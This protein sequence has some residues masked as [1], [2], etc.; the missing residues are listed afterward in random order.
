MFSKGRTRSK[1]TEPTHKPSPRVVPQTSDVSTR[2]VSPASIVQRAALAPASLNPVEVLRL[3]RTLGNRAVG[4]LLSGRGQRMTIQPKLAVNV[5]GDKYEQ[6]AD[7]I[8]GQLSKT[9]GPPEHQTATPLAQHQQGGEFDA[10]LE[11]AVREAKGGGRHLAAGIRQRA[12]Q[13]LGADFS[14]VN[15][16]TDARADA[17]N[18]SLQARA[19][20][21]GRDIFFRQGEYRPETRG[22]QEL[23]AHELTHVAQQSGGARRS[24]VGPESTSASSSA[25]SGNVFVQRKVWGP[26]DQDYETLVYTGVR[27]RPTKVKGK[28]HNRN[29]GQRGRTP[30]AMSLLHDPNN[31]T[32]AADKRLGFDGG[33]ILGLSLGGE[34]EPYNIVPMYPGFNRGTWKN[35]ENKIGNDATWAYSGMNFSVTINLTYAGPTDEIPQSLSA[36]GFA[37]VTNSKTK[38]TTKNKLVADYGTK[39]QPTDI[40]TTGRLTASEEKVVTGNEPKKTLKKVITD[41]ADYFQNTL[42]DAAGAKHLRKHGHLRR[43]DRID[44]PDKHTDRPYEYLDILTF[45]GKVNPG[46]TFTPRQIFSANQRALILQANMARNG[47]LLQ[48]DDPNDPIYKAPYLAASLSEQ[49]AANFPEIDHIIPKSLGGSNMFSNARVVSW[50]LN[51]KMDRVKDISGLVDVTRTSLPALPTTGTIEDKVRILVP[52]IL[53]RAAAALDIGGIVNEIRTQYVINVTINW[54]TAIQGLLDDMEATGEVTKNASDE[55]KIV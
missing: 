5:P 30:T 12:E 15:V 39:T 51:N 44:Y 43:S 3:Q 8:A 34:D 28:V 50:L 48:S 9:A 55:Y 29:V 54:R 46:T 19:F 20:T 14:N 52:A 23:I 49:G 32:G 21:M 1:D 6:E 33:H 26:P 40:E 10:G 41:A 42:G 47:G 7:R 31:F 37:D 18:H 13:A 22:G 4:G 24:S 35:V 38:K 36:Q 11:S 25:P 17:L 27:E 53:M 16:H 2:H 45:A